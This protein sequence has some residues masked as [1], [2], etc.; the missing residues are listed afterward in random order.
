[1][2]VHLHCAEALARGPGEV[3]TLPQNPAR[4]QS[5]PLHTSRVLRFEKWLMPL[6]VSDEQGHSGRSAL[7]IREVPFVGDALQDGWGIGGSPA[8]NC[9]F[10][11]CIIHMATRRNT[12]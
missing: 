10:R 5:G 8:G 4:T 1:M 7:G 3:V 11:A 12:V 2:S 6:R 9:M